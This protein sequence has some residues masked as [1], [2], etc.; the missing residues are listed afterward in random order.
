MELMGHARVY[1]WNASRSWK[2]LG[3][4]LDGEGDEHFWGNSVSLAADGMT[5]TIGAL[6]TG[7][8]DNGHM[9]VYM[10][11]STPPTWSQLGMDIDGD[12]F[13]G[14]IGLSLSSSESGERLAM[15]TPFCDN[16]GGFE[17]AG[18]AQVYVWNETSSMEW[19]Q[20]GVDFEGDA[21][22]DAKGYSVSLYSDG[23]RV[24]IGSPAKSDVFGE[25]I[26]WPSRG[27]RVEHY[28]GTRL[29]ESGRLQFIWRYGLRFRYLEMDKLLLLALLASNERILAAL[30]GVYSQV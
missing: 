2:K 11:G 3:Q 21:Y 15:G 8:G 5:I 30:V 25:A 12:D 24:A 6:R 1:Q 7:D 18:H 28:Y 13:Y 4:D 29:L 23:A 16:H 26:C 14:M 17:S 19:A 10:W 20:L 22:C 27:L 9:R